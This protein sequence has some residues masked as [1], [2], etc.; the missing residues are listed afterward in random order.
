MFNQMAIHSWLSNAIHDNL[1]YVILT[2]HTAHKPEYLLNHQPLHRRHTPINSHR[3]LDKI[4]RSGG[5]QSVGL[6]TWSSFA[7]KFEKS[8]R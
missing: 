7:G 6:W 3:A 8:F 2:G 1:L 4:I 5:L